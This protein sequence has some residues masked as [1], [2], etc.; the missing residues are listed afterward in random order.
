[1]WVVYDAQGETL[2]IISVFSVFRK[3]PNGL[4]A[5]QL[6]LGRCAAGQSYYTYNRG[7]TRLTTVGDWI[8]RWLKIEGSNAAKDCCCRDHTDSLFVGMTEEQSYEFRLSSILG[9]MQRVIFKAKLS[10][11]L[12]FPTIATVAWMLPLVAESSLSHILFQ[13]PHLIL[14]PALASVFSVALLLKDT[15]LKFMQ[16]DLP[17][18]SSL[19]GCQLYACGSALK[20]INFC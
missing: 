7:T 2:P 16:S 5:R 15:M 4:N 11:S 12:I 6:C 9:R 3:Y 17:I 13:N 19:M 1:M 8:R 18:T 14:S 20:F 10:Q